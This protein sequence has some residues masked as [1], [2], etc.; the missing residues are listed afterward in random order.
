[1]RKGKRGGAFCSTVLPSLTPW[2]LLNYT[3]RVRDVAT[4]AHELGHAIHSMLAEGHSVLTQQPTL[5]LAETASV[6][7]EMLLT[8]Q[9]LNVETD[10]LVRRELLAGFLAGLACQT[11]GMG[12]HGLANRGDD[13]LPL[14]KAEL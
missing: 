10:P 2:V 7:A 14:L 9:F 1:M 8:E 11:Y 6:F 12:H 13:D 3:G 4:L 5:P